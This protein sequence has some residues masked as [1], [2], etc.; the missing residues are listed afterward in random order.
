MSGQ[1]NVPYTL[2]R[3]TIEDANDLVAFEH[4]VADPKLYGPILDLAGA[5]E[6]IER[7][8]FYFIK[9]GDAVIGTAA[10]QVR[11]DQTVYIGNVAV[12][13]IYR[14]Q[15]IAHEVVRRILEAC[16]EA[17][18]VELV[19][20]PENEDALR[21]YKSLGFVVEGRI[22]NYFGDGE[23]RLLLALVPAPQAMH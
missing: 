3:A 21:L 10:Y 14:R 18:R 6:Q 7:N 19:T 1:P 8:I 22:E 4:R 17:R 23:P 13:P 15:G 20:H 5:I 2:K 9:L 11:T 12:D 16:R